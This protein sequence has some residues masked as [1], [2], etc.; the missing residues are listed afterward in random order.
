VDGEPLLIAVNLS[1][2]QFKS[3]EVE[4]E[5]VVLAALEASGLP[6]S[7]L[8]LEITESILLENVEGVLQSLQRLKQIG[9]KLS[10]DDF[11][12]GYSSL[13]Y[14]KR[15]R[16]DKLKID[17][18]FVRDLTSDPNDEAI[19]QAIIQM[20]HSLNLQIIAEGVEDEATL[21]ALRALECDEVQGYIY[22]RPL[23]AEA[24]RAYVD[25]HAT[26]APGAA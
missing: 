17:Q 11:G 23:A 24:F 22:S 20:G 26:V 12:T 2:V 15:F 1:A 21:A 14:L 25:R 10:I 8:E 19:I 4:L 3:R 16:I 13:A 9:V 7:R 5:S 6:P 18:S